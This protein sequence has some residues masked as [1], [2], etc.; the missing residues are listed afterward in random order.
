MRKIQRTT[1]IGAIL[2]AT[3]V[4]AT[5]AGWAATRGLREVASEVVVP[6]ATATAAAEAVETAATSTAIPTPVPP[7]AV[8]T[9][10][11]VSVATVMPVVLQKDEPF[12]IDL[13]GPGRSP[14]R[15]PQPS[16][17]TPSGQPSST[18][19]PVDPALREKFQI[20]GSLS[21]NGQRSVADNGSLNTPAVIIHDIPTN[22]DRQVPVPPRGR[23]IAGDAIQIGYDFMPLWSPSQRFARFPYHSA[24]SSPNEINRLMI[25]VDTETGTLRSFS[26]DCRGGICVPSWAPDSDRMIVPNGCDGTEARRAVLDATTGR[27]TPLPMGDNYEVGGGGVTT[28]ET[29]G[30][31]LVFDSDGRQ[32]GSF[33]GGSLFEPGLPTGVQAMMTPS[34]PQY[35]AAPRGGSCE[36]AIVYLPAD[37]TTGRC[38]TPPGYW[39]GTRGRLV[40]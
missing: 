15:V 35:A 4:V 10:A 20:R 2:A 22:A 31:A 3:V 11:P 26:D 38:I 21:P 1:V 19:A 37:G 36:G 13:V 9:G 5:I 16:A 6:T 17:N 18:P 33:D 14:R 24:G 30:R 7:P 28:V 23:P 34:G 32:V 8:F 40:P 29:L 39:E 12:A 27:L 25:V